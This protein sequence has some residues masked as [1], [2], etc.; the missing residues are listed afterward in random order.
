MTQ[1]MSTNLSTL[2]ADLVM[3][4]K[5]VDRSGIPTCLVHKT[6]R[7]PLLMLRRAVEKHD[8]VL[9]IEDADAFDTY[10]DEI[11]DSFFSY[12]SNK[13]EMQN[14]LMLENKQNKIFNFICE[15]MPSFPNME[16]FETLTNR[17]FWWLFLYRCMTAKIEGMRMGCY[18]AEAVMYLK[19][20]PGKNSNSLSFLRKL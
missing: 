11:R 14:V 1:D 5:F 4:R 7:K 2:L 20:L 9:G 17:Q 13:N 6:E 15:T 16:N 12:M 19:V 18:L 10:K 3:M 8:H